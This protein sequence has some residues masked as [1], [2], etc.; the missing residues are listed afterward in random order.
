MDFIRDNLGPTIAEK[1]RIEG[2]EQQVVDY[3]Q[4]VCD[5]KSQIE[6]LKIKLNENNKP[7]VNGSTEVKPDTPPSSTTNDS[8]QQAIE[9]DSKTVENNQSSS[10]AENDESTEK[11]NVESDT[12]VEPTTI[13]GKIGD[14]KENTSENGDNKVSNEQETN[15]DS[16]EK[17]DGTAD[18][19]VVKTEPNN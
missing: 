5:L 7:I 16:K 4:E 19:A 14:E 9:A 13:N 6:E 12:K 8:I 10:N 1:H 17:S 3:K 11:I 2:L 18:V 15:V